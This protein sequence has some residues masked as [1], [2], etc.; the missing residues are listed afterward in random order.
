MDLFNVL[1]SFYDKNKFDKISDFDLG[2]NFFMINRFC[3]I[4][5]PILAN[6]FNHLKINGVSVV[7]VWQTLL[8]RKYSKS[9]HWMFVKIKKEKKEQENKKYYID[10]NIVSKYCEL[11]EITKREFF[12]KLN[13]FGD[14][15]Y[16]EVIQYKDLVE[17]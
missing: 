8:S 1:N 11:N 15:F 6:N 4:N 5:Y 9:P 10:D 3:S 16:K 2:K 14:N 12:E 7:K 17:K 13:F